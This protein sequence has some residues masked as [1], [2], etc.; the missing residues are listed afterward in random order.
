MTKLELKL[1]AVIKG[2]RTRRLQP[3]QEVNVNNTS[4]N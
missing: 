2:K 4:T 3:M 1:I